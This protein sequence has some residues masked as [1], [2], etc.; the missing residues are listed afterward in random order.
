MHIFVWP[1]AFM[2]FGT[3]PVRDCGVTRFLHAEHFEGLPNSFLKWLRCFT[4]RPAERERPVSSHPHQ[5]CG[6]LPHPYEA[7]LWQPRGEGCL[8]VVWTHCARRFVTLSVLHVLIAYYLHNLSSLKTCIF[9][10]CARFLSW[11]V[12]SLLTVL[13]MC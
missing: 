4:A 1:Y 7:S 12:F 8:T 13:C 10:S 6:R 3:M 2:S 9:I 5:R 11:V